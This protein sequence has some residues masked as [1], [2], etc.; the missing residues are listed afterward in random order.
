MGYVFILLAAVRTTG[1][2]ADERMAEA[3]AV[4]RWI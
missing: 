4:S 3:S 2:K 1:A